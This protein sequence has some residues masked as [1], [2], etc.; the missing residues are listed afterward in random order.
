MKSFPPRPGDVPPPPRRDSF[1]IYLPGGV[2]V[3][4]AAVEEL[5]RSGWDDVFRQR[6]CEIS[7][8]FEG[9]F[10]SCGQEDL[11]TI[12]RSITMLLE[13]SPEQV[14]D[15]GAALQDK[16]N[17]LLGQLEVRLKSDEETGTG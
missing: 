11:A 9:S 8:A 4:R 3:L 10:R 16:L 17:E 1:L 5:L 2:P 7:C 6:A 13:L 12:A 14:S 15:L